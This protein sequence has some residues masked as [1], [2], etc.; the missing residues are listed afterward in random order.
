MRLSAGTCS[1][2]GTG[3]AVNQDSVTFSVLDD[4]ALLAVIADGLGGYAQSEVASA[5]AASLVRAHIEQSLRPRAPSLEALKR[6]VQAANL[7]LWQHAIEHEQPMKTTLT[8]LICTPY[9][10][11]LAHVGDCRLYLLRSGEA[12]LLT[13]DH[14]WAGE[15]A[16]WRSLLRATLPVSGGHTRHS[17]TR[18]L[19]DQPI[20]RVDT[21]RLAAQPGDRFILCSDGVWSGLAPGRLIELAGEQEDDDV[22]ARRL[23]REA[24]AGGSSDDVSAIVVSLGRVVVAPEL[25]A[26]SS[27][28]AYQSLGV[29]NG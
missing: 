23:A 5:L 9:E 4:Q 2:R 26:H 8:A 12:R 7:A 22:L 13:R 20:V 10:A 29:A 1:A 24:Q 25:D 17:L 11:F 15:T 21:I 14:S 18:V 28:H 3:R 6:A 19:G 16:G 27:S